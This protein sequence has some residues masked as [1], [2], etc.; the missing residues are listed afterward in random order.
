MIPDSHNRVIG[1]K[2]V[3]FSIGGVQVGS[4]AFFMLLGVFAALLWYSYQSSRVTTGTS[5]SWPVIAGALL[6][7]SLGAKLAG[8]LLNS[9]HYSTFGLMQFLYSGRS[10]LGGLILGWV[11]VKL[12]KR[13]L[14]ITGKY[15]NAIAPAAALGIAIGRIGCF[16]G[17]CCYG[18]PTDWIW[19]V[20]FGDGV[21]RHPTQVYEAIF[22]LGLCA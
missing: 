1:L 6:F 2:P 3:L 8:V 22:S 16:L 10:I 21:M 4:Y 11:G 9:A 12:T 19:G 13:V 7:G 20:N 5:R 15:G 18:K 17:S 14:G